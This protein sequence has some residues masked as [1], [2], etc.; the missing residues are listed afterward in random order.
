MGRAAAN[1]LVV[2]IVGQ[3]EQRRGLTQHSFGKRPRPLF[4]ST[5]LVHEQELGRMNAREPIGIV[6]ISGRHKVRQ[7]PKFITQ[8]TMCVRPYVTLEP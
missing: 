3:C 5:N 8:S 4:S 7:T 2:V 6:R 1:A